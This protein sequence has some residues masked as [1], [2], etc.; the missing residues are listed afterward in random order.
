MARAA[1]TAESNETERALVMVSRPASASCRK[2]ES[3]A[4]PMISCER[5]RGSARPGGQHLGRLNAG[6]RGRWG[7]IWGVWRALGVGSSVW[8]RCCSGAINANPALPCSRR[9]QAQ[10][11]AW[12][13]LPLREAGVRGGHPQRRAAC[14]CRAIAAA[15]VLRGLALARGS[16]IRYQYA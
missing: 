14:A 6:R 5:A 1:K 8:N 2:A 12:F 4:R 16:R 3:V 15:S 10:R 11:E 13:L 9:G 7:R